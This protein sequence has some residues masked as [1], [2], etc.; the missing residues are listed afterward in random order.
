MKEINKDLPRAQTM[1]ASFG[2]ALHLKVVTGGSW[3]W[4]FE[5]WWRALMGEWWWQR[6]EGG[7][8]ARYC[9]WW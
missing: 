6:W 9:G 1:I 8:A 3:G 2:P 5:W 4:V 7:V